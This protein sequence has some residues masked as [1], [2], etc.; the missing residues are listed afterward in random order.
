VG[1]GRGGGKKWG[2]VAGLACFSL[3]ALVHPRLAPRLPHVGLHPPLSCPQ[4]V[5]TALRQANLL[6]THARVCPQEAGQI[7]YL[8]DGFTKTVP[9][10]DLV[11]QVCVC[12]CVCVCI[13]E[14]VFACL[15]FS[16]SFTRSTCPPNPPLIDSPNYPTRTNPPS[17]QL[18]QP[19]PLPPSHSRRPARG[20]A[21]GPTRSGKAMT[22]S[23]ATPTSSTPLT[24]AAGRAAATTA[25]P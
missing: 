23:T 7:F 12:V 24:A 16:Q 20:P 22:L 8:L 2:R 4:Q 5:L 18:A 19:S 15:A 14:C 10:L 1:H 17:P 25:T 3:L 11:Q 13:R 9:D 21:G 6:I